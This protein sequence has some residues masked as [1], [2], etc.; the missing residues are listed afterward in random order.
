MVMKVE[1][2]GGSRIVSVP[3]VFETR[4]MLVLMLLGLT[5]LLNKWQ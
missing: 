5:E 2:V 3:W 4:R 1:T